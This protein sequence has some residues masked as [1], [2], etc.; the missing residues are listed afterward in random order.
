MNKTRSENRDYKVY[1]I[2]NSTFP[3]RQMNWSKYYVDE[4]KP[5]FGAG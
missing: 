2:V 5:D 1:K 4:P 3:M